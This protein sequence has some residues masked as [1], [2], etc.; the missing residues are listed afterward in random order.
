MRAIST[1]HRQ[2]ARHLGFNG[3]GVGVMPAPMALCAAGTGDT[4]DTGGASLGAASTV[5]VTTA[6]SGVHPLVRPLR[7][8]LELLQQRGQQFADGRVDVH[9]PCHL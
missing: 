7:H 2:L 4:G 5:A 6:L 8:R 9:R 1:A 3:S